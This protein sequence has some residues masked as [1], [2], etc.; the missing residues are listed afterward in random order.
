MAYFIFNLEDISNKYK[1]ILD[2]AL[3][4]AAVSRTHDII[5]TSY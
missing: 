2:D 4:L 5:V 1:M 3:I